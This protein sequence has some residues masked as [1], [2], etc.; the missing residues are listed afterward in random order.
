VG[1]G[2]KLGRPDRPAVTLQG[3]GGFMYTVQEL[4]TAVRWKIPHVSIVLNNGCHGSEKAQQQRFWNERYVGVELDNPRF[5]KVAEAFGA[6]G[7]HVTRP[8]D[9]GE[10]VKAALAIDGPTVVEIPVAQYFPHPPATPG[11]GERQH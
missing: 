11:G 8:Q 3:D 4:N 5:D 2:T 7:F 10:A 9:I 6:S 1:L